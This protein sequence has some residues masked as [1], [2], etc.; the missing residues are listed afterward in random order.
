MEDPIVARLA[1]LQTTAITIGV[2]PYK[3]IQVQQENMQA[4]FPE[5]AEEIKKE[6]EGIIRCL[7][8]SKGSR[9]I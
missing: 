4:A 8:T 5:L 6:N 1:I 3:K 9:A 2:I 7:P